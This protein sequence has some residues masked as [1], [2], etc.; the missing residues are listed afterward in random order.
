MRCNS[1]HPSYSCLRL[2]RKWPKESLYTQFVRPASNAER[3]P[4]CT[5]TSVQMGY[6]IS[7]AMSAERRYESATFVRQAAQTRGIGRRG[8]PDRRGTV[9][10]RTSLQRPFTALADLDPV[11]HVFSSRHVKWPKMSMFGPGP[12]KRFRTCPYTSRHPRGSG[13]PGRAK[14]PVIGGFPLPRE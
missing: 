6:T 11:I 8:L 9:G 5:R 12:G 13:G 4:S 1:S 3:N 2:S 7:I 14:R 10:S